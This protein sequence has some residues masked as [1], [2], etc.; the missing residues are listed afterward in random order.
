MRAA[1]S[2]NSILILAGLSFGTAAV[3]QQRP[4]TVTST[5][6]L[7][8]IIIQENRLAAPLKAANRNITIISSKQIA[9]MAVTSINQV[10]AFIPGLDVRQRGPGGV[11]ADIGIDGGTFDQTLIL[12]NG[13]KITDPQTGHNMMNLPVSLQDVDHIEVLRGAAARV[14]GI[15]ALNGAI[16]IVT[17]KATE[18]ELTL[19]ASGGSNFALNDERNMYGGVS[20]G[21]TGSL[22]KNNNSHTVSLERNQG[23]GYRYNTDYDNFRAFYEGGFR[24]DTNQQYQVMAGFVS[25]NYG[26]N[27]FYAPPGDKES[28]ETIK[29]VLAAVSHTRRINPHW[30]MTPRI[31]YRYTFDDYL[32]IKQ[33]PDKFRNKHHTQVLDAEWNNTIDTRIG[34]FGAGLEARFEH[35]NSSNLGDHNRTNLGLFAEYK[36]KADRRLTYTIGG[37][38]NYNSFYGWQFFPGADIGFN[39]TPDLKLFANVGTAQR[40]PTYTDL[41]YK[42]P[43]ILGND[44]LGPE[45]ATYAEAGIR[46]YSGHFSFTASAFFRQVSDFIDY[47]KDTAGI[48]NPATVPWQPHNLNQTNVTGLTFNAG[49]NTVLQPRGFFNSFGVNAGYNY[50]SPEF[51]GSAVMEHKISRYVI[52]SLK[53]QVTGTAQVAFLQHFSLSASARYNMRVSYTDYMVVDAR[54]AYKRSRYQ[55]YADA[56]NLLDVTYIEAAAVPMPGR[57]ITLGGSVRF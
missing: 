34:T 55:I 20:T 8:E 25:N 29:T 3:A 5:R 37:Y 41:Y 46:R 50:L 15:N 12:L 14:Y 40:L 9:A 30:V 17:R 48:P 23:N 28:E 57:W 36:S 11:Q 10:L 22:V 19:R 7:D 4:D 39:I 42:S 47:V 6:H 52:E 31:S 21:L 1:I 43:A 13:V 54:V 26:A 56:N 24:K 44:Q 2:Y 27:G 33:T 16:N 53:H 38:L 49:Y 32:Y 51:K 18:T 35:I 45:R